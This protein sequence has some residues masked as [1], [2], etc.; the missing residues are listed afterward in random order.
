MSQV[1]W[2]FGEVTNLE[3]AFQRTTAH[4]AKQKDASGAPVETLYRGEIQIMLH[5]AASGAPKGA[6]GKTIVAYPANMNM[7]RIPLMGEHVL[8]FQGPGKNMGPQ[9][10]NPKSGDQNTGNQFDLEWYYFDPLS[11]QG[12]IHAN[13]N[14]GANVGV[15]M[16][17][18]GDSTT[19]QDGEKNSK[20]ELYDQS[21]AGN[22]TT[23]SA[24]TKSKTV[25][26]TQNTTETE[27]G[28]DF[29]ELPNINNLQPFEG[30]V[31]LQG[32]SGHSIRLGATINVSSESELDNRYQEM[33]TWGSGESGDQGPIIIMRAGQADSQQNEEN[34]YIIEKINEDKSSIY[35]CSGQKIEIS[36]A[37]PKFDALTEQHKSCPD[38]ITDETGKCSINSTHCNAFACS[39]S[40]I[41]PLEPIPDSVNELPEVPG[42]WPKYNTSTGKEISMHKLRIIDNVPFFESLCPPVLKMMK[43][44]KEDGVTI[45]LTSGYRGVKDVVVDG[46]KYATGQL[47]LR[48]QNAKNSSWKTD[49]MWNDTTS[50]LWTARSS[51]FKPFTAAPGRSKHQSGIAIDMSTHSRTSKTGVYAWLVNNAYKYGFVRTVSTEEWH[52]EYIPHWSRTFASIMA[53]HKSW[54]GHGLDHVQNAPGGMISF[55][56]LEEGEINTGT[57]G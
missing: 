45:R 49:A 52:W 51:K 2:A 25:P 12:S 29:K 26:E 8:C 5:A 44:A 32:R 31:I 39:T 54:H 22:P 28:N 40:P 42:E 46:K 24:A 15:A 14:P 23:N 19:V 34:N 4:D 17:G 53:S 13:L 57:N 7:T 55:G 1:T 11:I 6:P 47:T 38:S 36:I 41:E 21:A 10:A 37:S 30:D 56:N 20:A 18:P 35:I 33:P 3:N 50:K 9:G 27:P 16:G 43:A 48:K